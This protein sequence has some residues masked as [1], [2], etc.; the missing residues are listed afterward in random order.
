MKVLEKKVE[1]EEVLKESTTNLQE[2]NIIPNFEELMQQLIAKKESLQSNIEEGK[3]I[4]KFC[5][6]EV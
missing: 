1:S 2:Q 5:K 6:G 3:E 4:K